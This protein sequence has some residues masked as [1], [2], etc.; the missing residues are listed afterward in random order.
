MR[1]WAV[2]ASG[3]GNGDGELGMKKEEER[4]KADV[5]VKRAKLTDGYSVGK[6]IRAM[7]SCLR[8]M[9]TDTPSAYI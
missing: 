5:L 3:M 1:W 7:P 6:S 8:A 9:P 4:G 2:V